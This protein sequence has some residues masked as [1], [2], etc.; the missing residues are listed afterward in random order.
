MLK[1]QR[2]RFGNPIECCGYVRASEASWSSR[3]YKAKETRQEDNIVDLPRAIICP[4]LSFFLFVSV[5]AFKRSCSSFHERSGRS[6]T[7]KFGAVAAA[8]LSLLSHVVAD[9]DTNVAASSKSRIALPSTFKP[10]Q[11]FQNENLV[12]I[13]SLEKNY[14]KETI[15]VVIKNIS[16]EPQDEYYL[17]FTGSQMEKSGGFEVKDKKDDAVS[18]FTVD[19]VEFDT[20]RYG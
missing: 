9:A 13:I 4:I 15:N 1:Q 3:S 19:A 11:V 17:P 16:P 20:Y 5:A 2:K 18:G 12:H 6:F 7:M 8:C 14:A 10:P